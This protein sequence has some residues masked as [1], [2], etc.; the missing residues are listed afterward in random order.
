MFD[1]FPGGVNARYRESMQALMEMLRGAFV[2]DLCSL[3]RGGISSV[4][5]LLA[6]GGADLGTSTQLDEPCEERAAQTGA[7]IFNSG[8]CHSLLQQ[9]T[10]T[11]S[12]L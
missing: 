11:L 1:V 4:P 2:P 3:V 9:E 10:R 5:G 7:A 8:G 12:V 6:L